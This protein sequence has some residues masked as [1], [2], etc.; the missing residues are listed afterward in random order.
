MIR[1]EDLNILLSVLWVVC[2]LIYLLGDVIRI[3]A[4]D[5]TKGKMG[6]KSVDQKVWISAAMFMMIPIV[7][8]FLSLIIGF[9]ANSYLNII[10]A[11]FM[12]FFNLL[13]LK[14]YK[15]YDQILLVISFIFNALTIYYATTGF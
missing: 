4:G 5:F 6:G 13:G 1:E 8:V 9:P 2:I 14:G 15:L 7:M 11:S 3:F 12:F 10:I